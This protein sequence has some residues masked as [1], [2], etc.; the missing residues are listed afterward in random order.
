VSVALLLPS[1]GSSIVVSADLRGISDLLR[2][3]RNI[4]VEGEIQQR[5]ERHAG[6][7]LIQIAAATRL[8]TA[9]TA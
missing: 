9:N 8:R 2:Q 6:N 3:T 7:G 4:A 1:T 5:A